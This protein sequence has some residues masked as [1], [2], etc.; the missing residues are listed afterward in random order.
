[1]IRNATHITLAVGD[2][3]EALAWFT[4]KLGLEPRTGNAWGEGYR[5]ATVGFRGQ[6]LNNTEHTA[7]R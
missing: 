5:F 4:E 7:T 6:K 1:M 2:H 3:D